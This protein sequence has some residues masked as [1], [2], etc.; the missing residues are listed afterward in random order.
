MQELD[1][2]HFFCTLQRIQIRVGVIRT[3]IAEEVS[4]S[5]ESK[6]YHGFPYRAV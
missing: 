6:V 4:T 3:R 5:V 2:F 1:Y